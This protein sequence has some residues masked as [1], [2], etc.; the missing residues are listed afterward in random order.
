[1]FLDNKLKFDEHLQYITNKVNK[2]TGQLRTL[3]MIL[4]RQ[5][6]ITLYKSLIRPHLDHGD[7]IFDQ[8]FNKSFDDNIKYNA[9]LAITGAIRVTSKEK[10]D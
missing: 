3:Q 6:L 5:S 9:S 1:M 8:T 4:P 10:R 2:S 7:I